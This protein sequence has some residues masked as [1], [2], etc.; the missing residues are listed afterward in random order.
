MLLKSRSRRKPHLMVAHH[1]TTHVK[2]SVFALFRPQRGISRI[3]LHSRRQVEAVER[4]LGLPR[5]QLAFV[6]YFADTG[7]WSPRDIAE[8]AIVVTAGRE[9]RDYA[10]LAEACASIPERVVVAAGSFHSPDAPWRAPASWPRNFEL[11]KMLDRVAL[12]E[13]YARAA[14]VVVPVLPTDFQAGVTTLL[15]AMS[16]GKAVIVSATEGQRDIVEDGETGVL[17]TPGDASELRRSVRR[18]ID[19]PDERKRLGGNA[20]RAA[21]TRFSLDVYASTLAG[22]LGELAKFGASEHA[23]TAFST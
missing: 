16:M 21:E 17:V 20:R 3:L 18:L 9:H 23:A 15:E 19:N 4:E 5:A 2:R 7:F 14:V 8:E 13:L 22:H 1:V 6:P 10:T 11:L 12:R